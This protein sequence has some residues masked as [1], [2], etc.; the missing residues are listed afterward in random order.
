MTK[1]TEDNEFWPASRRESRPWRQSTRGGT[2]ADRTMSEVIVTLPPLISSQPIALT[3]NQATAMESAVREVTALDYSNGHVLKALGLLLLRSESVASSKI[4]HIEASVDDYARALHGVKSNSSAVAMVYA[5]DALT[6]LIDRVHVGR[7]IELSSITEAHAVLMK[8]ES[9]ER[10]YA[11]QLRTMQNWVGGSDHSPR[12]ALFVPP[13]P[14]LVAGHMEDLI[15]FMG[16]DDLPALAQAAIA[17]AQ[18]ETIHP[19][20]DGN[21]RIGRALINSILRRRG[22][23][24]RVVV[25]LA[26][27]LVAHREQYFAALEAYRNGHLD[28]LLDLFASAALLSAHESRVTAK[29]L[30]EIPSAWADMVGKVRGGSTTSRLLTNLLD[31]PI[32]STDDAITLT[33]STSSRTYAAVEQLAAAQV[34][35]PLTTRVRNQ[36]WGARMVLDELDDLASRVA[37]ANSGALTLGHSVR[38]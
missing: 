2:K 17:H 30:E 6:I 18:F 35:T 19:F 22:V 33:G 8:S 1:T 28:P 7:Q 12:N 14:E 16:R 26:T 34:L 25:P 9:D 32:I 36:I 10:G 21:G 38:P 23:T 3:G 24:E 5:T 37:H 11:G 4:E 20:T 15:S 27:A 31:H 13:P 29:R